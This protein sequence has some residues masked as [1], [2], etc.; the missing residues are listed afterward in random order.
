MFFNTSPQNHSVTF[1]NGPPLAGQFQTAK[2]HFVINAVNPPKII[3]PKIALSY[4]S[5]ILGDL[6]LRRSSAGGGENGG[7]KKWKSALNI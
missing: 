6:S 4:P 1:E 3:G 5:I 7:F 2:I